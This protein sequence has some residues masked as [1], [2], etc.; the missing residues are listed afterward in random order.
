MLVEVSADQL[1]AR[2]MYIKHLTLRS[3][4]LLEIAFVIGKLKCFELDSVVSSQN[5]SYTWNR[6][7]LP[8]I[9]P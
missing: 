9:A 4:P 1:R 5:L 3:S 7:S 6:Y 2:N 8:F